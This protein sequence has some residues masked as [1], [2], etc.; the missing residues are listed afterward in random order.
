M[1]GSHRSRDDAGPG[2]HGEPEK[3]AMSLIPVVR[4]ARAVEAGIGKPHVYPLQLRR[5][6]GIHPGLSQA[7]EIGKGVTTSQG[8]GSGVLVEL[9]TT[10]WWLILREERTRQQRQ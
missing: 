3:A 1:E 7:V 5:Q 8:G 10:G 6:G 2:R 9:L 4:G